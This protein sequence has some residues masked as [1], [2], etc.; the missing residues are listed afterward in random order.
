M[1]KVMLL[2]LVSI[3][4]VSCEQYITEMKTVTLSG[5]YVISKMEVTN[6]EQKHSPDSLY[7]IGTTY[8]NKNLPDPFDN[9]TINRFYI[10]F[11]YTTVR[12]NLL[13]TLNSG[14]D[15]WQYGTSPDDIFYR[16]F[17]Q[18]PYHSG[19]IQYMYKSVKGEFPMVTFM[20]EDDGLTSLQLKSEGGWFK[21]QY[22]QKQVVTLFLTRVGP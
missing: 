4:F 8:I 7:L 11:D 6:V 22:G 10:H 2:L 1:R 5:K 13:G 21:G 3:L 20:I 14:R 12:M 17:G 15:Y 9:I 19:Y 16:L 18:T